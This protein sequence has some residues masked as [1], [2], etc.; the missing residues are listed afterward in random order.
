VLQT[1]FL[2]V[3]ILHLMVQ[4]CSYRLGLT[5]SDAIDDSS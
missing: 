3:C 5:S 4:W 1:V 2:S